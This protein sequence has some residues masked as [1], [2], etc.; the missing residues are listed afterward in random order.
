M[1]KIFCDGLY[2]D[3]VFC[4][5]MTGN[6]TGAEQLR[7]GLRD[8]AAMYEECV[9]HNKDM[10]VG[11]LR[12][13]FV[14]FKDYSCDEEPMIESEFFTLDEELDDALAFLEGRYSSGGGDMPECA[15]EAL[16]YAMR[17]DWTTEG[18]VK[19]HAICLVTDAPA[20]QLG[21]CSGCAGYPDDMP[22]SLNELRELWESGRYRN[23]KRLLLIT[24]ECEPW[25]DLAEWP[26]TFMH[27]VTEGNGCTDVDVLQAV[28][29]ILSW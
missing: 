9:S 22:K 3:I 24:P 21:V 28:A 10:E 20:K 2:T 19:R 17:S 8:F 27:R 11:R 7:Y 5:D 25:M 6:G 12:V 15:L 26:Y 13:R 16:A 4:L 23:A 1:D 18:S 14:L 29:Q